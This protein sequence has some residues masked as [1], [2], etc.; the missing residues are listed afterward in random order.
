MHLGRV[1]E[2]CLIASLVRLEDN[3]GDVVFLHLGTLDQLNSGQLAMNRTMNNELST[4]LV[5][6]GDIFGMVLVVVDSE[7]G[8]RNLRLKGFVPNANQ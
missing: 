7:R 5:G 6:N 2:Q 4:D 3:G 8:L 1:V